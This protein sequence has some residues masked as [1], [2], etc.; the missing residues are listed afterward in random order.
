MSDPQTTKPLV[1]AADIL[2]EADPYG[3]QMSVRENGRV[4]VHPNDLAKA[5]RIADQRNAEAANA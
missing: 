1:T 3:C 5:Q 2:W 4:I